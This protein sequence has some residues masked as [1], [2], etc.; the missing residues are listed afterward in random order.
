M[1]CLVKVSY[2]AVSARS[3]RGHGLSVKLRVNSDFHLTVS[4]K[5]L[6]PQN[7]FTCDRTL[8]NRT[9]PQA[10]PPIGLYPQLGQSGSTPSLKPRPD[11]NMFT[12]KNVSSTKVR[13]EDGVP[14]KLNP[15]LASRLKT[16]VVR[17]I[18]ISHNERFLRICFCPL[19]T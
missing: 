8:S 14:F 17:L 16:P 13:G 12:I 9:E 3:P 4:A 19:K 7:V 5:L 18:F 11:G 15:Q 10:P 6:P 2:L 1:I